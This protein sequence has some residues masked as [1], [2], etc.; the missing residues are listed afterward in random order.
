VDI[1]VAPAIGPTLGP[2]HICQNEGRG[3]D[4]SVIG[5][6][7]I[8]L[9]RHGARIHTTSGRTVQVSGVCSASY[10]S[11]GTV[12]E[13]QSG[14]PLES[15]VTVQFNEMDSFEI[16]SLTTTDTGFVAGVTVRISALDGQVVTGVVD[17]LSNDWVVA[18]PS[19]DL[20]EY[21]VRL[22]QVRRVEFVGAMP[23]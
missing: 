16:V 3:P 2:V 10:A 20:G 19:P 17:T 9:S 1:P 13:V 6:G 7:P 15:G 22:H 12:R 8:I 21:E 14:L 4:S 23:S 18:G 11:I 5:E